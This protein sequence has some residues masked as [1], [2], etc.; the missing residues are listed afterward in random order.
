MYLN[1]N[2]DAD[3]ATDYLMQDDILFEMANIQKK[4]TG[5]PVNLWVDEHGVSRNNEHN[6]PRL[7]FQANKSD[8][9]NGEG[10][11]ISISANPEILVA[12]A[13]TELS[14]AEINMIKV[15]II[16]H[17]ELFLEHWLQ[18]IDTDELK[19]KLKSER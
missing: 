12:N 3:K 1:D 18:E 17:L 11:P 4:I 10:I 16:N 7:K 13:H 5:L 2:I 8:K 19:E 9:V 6:L 14:D 15:F